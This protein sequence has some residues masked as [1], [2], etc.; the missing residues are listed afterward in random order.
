M[1]PFVDDPS[2]DPVSRARA[3]QRWEIS[4]IGDRDPAE[5]QEQLPSHLEE[6][7]SEAGPRLAVRPEPDAWSPV[8]TLAHLVDTE[9]LYAA[10]YRYILAHD[11]PPLAGF[12]PDLVM[13]RLHPRPQDEDPA[14]LLDV[15]SALRR[16]NLALWRAT[17]EDDRARGAMHPERGA[18]S[19]ETEF[20]QIAGHD[21]L[22][23]DQIR[24]ALGGSA[25]VASDEPEVP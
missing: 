9:I 21:V 24:R 15:L 5:V 6:L 1:R 13:A 12:D 17:T 2:W 25:H 4:L 3:F 23:L 11:D 22:H 7:M 20:R 8:E 19:L 10:R 18:E 16:A 14:V